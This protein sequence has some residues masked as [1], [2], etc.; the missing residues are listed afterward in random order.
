MF[1]LVAYVTFNNIQL[2]CDG[3]Q[4]VCR[5]RL[6]YGRAP[7]DIYIVGVFKVHVQHRHR[8]IFSLLSLD[9]LWHNGI[10]THNLRMIL[11]P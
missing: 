1:E 4:A 10:R 7:N 9:S 5:R 11:M 2:H 8:T 3:V 6:T